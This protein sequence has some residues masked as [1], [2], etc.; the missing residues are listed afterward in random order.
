MILLIL[1]WVFFKIGLFTIGGGYAMISTMSDEVVN[2]GWIS[3]DLVS[4]FIGIA[5]STPG[6]L[7][8]NMATF[9]GFNQYGVLGAIVATLSVALPSF[10]II[11]IVAKMV[12][13]FLENKIVRYVVDGIK[14]AVIGL[15]F[16]TALYMVYEI[17]FHDVYNF[18]QIKNIDYKALIIVILIFIFSKLKIKGKKF[19]PIMLIIVSAGFGIILYGLIP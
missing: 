18:N 6:P 16:A 9:I 3:K 14:S 11:V 8:I 4:V 1:F 10:I 2:R 15:I 13:K 5:E 12:D 7:A 19:S 17:C